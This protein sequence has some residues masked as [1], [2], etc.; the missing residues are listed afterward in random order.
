MVYRDGI[1]YYPP[2][3]N[4]PW[5]SGSDINITVYANVVMVF[6]YTIVFDDGVSTR[7]NTVIIT[8]TPARQELSENTIY[9]FLGGTI[10]LG[11]VGMGVILRNKDKN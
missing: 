11:L 10:V 4:Q 8:I 1:D 7:N 5:T 2:Y 9:I 6:N 3:S